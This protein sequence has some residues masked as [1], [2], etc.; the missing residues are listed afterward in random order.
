MDKKIFLVLKS[1]YRKD[2]VENLSESDL[3]NWV[4]ENDY[5]S[6]DSIIKIDANGYD[7]PE[8]ALEKEISFAD[9][10]EYYVFSFGF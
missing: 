9:V 1:N 2:L 6:D 4:A 10:E 5:E 3:E 7:T 8:E